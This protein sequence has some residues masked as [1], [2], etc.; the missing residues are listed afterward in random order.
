MGI[1][2]KVSNVAVS[3]IVSDYSVSSLTYARLIMSILPAY[4][5]YSKL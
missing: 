5:N 4:E 1:I 3:A 2:C